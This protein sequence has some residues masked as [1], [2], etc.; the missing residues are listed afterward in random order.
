MGLGGRPDRR[1]ATRRSRDLR[2]ALPPGRAT[3]GP[4]RRMPAGS[5][6]M[7]REAA[8]DLLN[9]LLEADRA[10]VTVSTSY[11]RKTAMAALRAH[12]A[13]YCTGLPNP[14][15]LTD[16]TISFW[17]PAAPGIW[18]TVCCATMRSSLLLALPLRTSVAARHE[19]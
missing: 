2:W 8:V 18:A 15:R 7:D 5:V 4:A 3:R 14:V 6:T 12:E 16:T 19:T 11:G 17:T 13:R 1:A 9:M 10:G